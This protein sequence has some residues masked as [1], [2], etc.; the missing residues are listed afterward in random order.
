MV[1]LALGLIHNKNNI[2]N[3]QQITNLLSFVIPH[4]E[5]TGT[6]PE[7]EPYGSW[8]YSLSGLTIEH[9][10]KFFQVIPFG[11]NPPNNLNDLDSYKVFYRAGDENKTGTHQRFR[12]WAIKRAGDYGADIV[13]LI[14]EPAQF[15]IVGLEFQI[16]RLVDRRLLVVPLWGLAVSSR[17]FSLVGE[18]REN[19]SESAALDDL[20]ARIVAAGWEHG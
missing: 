16:G 17:L 11:V 4:F 2:G 18:F 20:R 14:T 8:W 5:Q 12:N 3:R 13:A 9:Q 10:V 1:N 15:T 19:L 7:G 6:S